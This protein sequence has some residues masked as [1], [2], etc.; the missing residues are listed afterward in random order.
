MKLDSLGLYQILLIFIFTWTIFYNHQFMTEGDISINF[1]VVYSWNKYNVLNGHLLDP[2][3]W[4][5]YP[6]L[7][8]LVISEFN[9]ECLKLIPDFLLIE[10]KI[11]DR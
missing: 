9:F 5:V 2:I 8:P 3:I 4:K 7:S 11:I 1:W 10:Y 6:L